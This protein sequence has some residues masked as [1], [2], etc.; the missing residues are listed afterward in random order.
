MSHIN[1]LKPDYD[2]TQR[3]HCLISF[4]RLWQSSK[5][6]K[7]PA[8]QHLY[9]FT[10][11]S[12][13]YICPALWG[14]GPHSCLPPVSPIWSPNQHH[15]ATSVQAVPRHVATQRDGKRA[16]GGGR[17]HRPWWFMLSIRG[18]FFSVSH[19]RNHPKKHINIERALRG[20]IMAGCLRCYWVELRQ[21]WMTDAPYIQK[22]E[23]T[24][25]WCE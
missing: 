23:G 15:G 12:V 13:Q 3:G 1:S 4:S 10:S 17:G 8:R 24:R 9:T 18:I 25:L 11:R 22:R 6:S 5:T 7:T 2:Q 19:W 20:E 14:C 21:A 16:V